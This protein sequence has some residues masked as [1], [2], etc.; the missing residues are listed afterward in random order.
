MLVIDIG[1]TS[2]KLL[3]TGQKEH[4]KFKS[5]PKLTPAIL[6]ARVR[7][8]A[9]DWKY[10]VVS[11]GYPGPVYHNR[12]VSEPCHLGRGW[13]AFDYQS[14]FERPVRII[15]DATMQALG[16]YKDGKMLF[17][18]LGTGFGSTMIMDGLLEPMELGH[19][20]YKRGTY[21]DY[22]GIC[23]LKK[24]GKKQWRKDVL[25]VVKRL[26]AALEPD[27]VVLGGGNVN[28][29]KLLPPGCRAGDNDN[30]FL[31]GFR[32]WTEPGDRRRST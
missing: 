2:V 4:C 7:K 6:V 9:E 21:E 32:L 25:D 17:M 5:G 23:G 8:L 15:N 31:G 12:P 3:A 20:P 14:S 28:K 13:V 24:H 10:D 1:G 27:D 30:A 16:S 22:V 19:L 29:L 26:V 18:G 11:I